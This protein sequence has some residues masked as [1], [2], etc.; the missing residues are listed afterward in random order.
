MDVLLPNDTSPEIV[1]E[2]ATYAAFEVQGV[3]APYFKTRQEGRTG[4]LDNYQQLNT[5]FLHS[6]PS[7]H[8]YTP[9]INGLSHTLAHLSKRLQHSLHFCIRKIKLYKI[10]SPSN[11]SPTVDN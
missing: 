3:P 10:N 2:V 11:P 9:S 1:A 7:F 4:K 6:T 8:R 5:L